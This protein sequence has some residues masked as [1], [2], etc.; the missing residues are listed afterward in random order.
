ML[1]FQFFFE[2][3]GKI[4]I[5]VTMAP[6]FKAPPRLKMNNSSLI[7]GLQMILT[8]IK[9][10]PTFKSLYIVTTAIVPVNSPALYTELL[11]KVAQIY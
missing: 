11:L 4:N 6:K 10:G 1:F 2:I 5:R 7:H 9:L 8:F 3:E